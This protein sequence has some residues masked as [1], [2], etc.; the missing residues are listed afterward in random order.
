MTG[1]VSHLVTEPW[2]NVEM[3]MS[4]SERQRNYR[5]RKGARVG[6]KPGPLPTEPCGTSAGAR[7]HERAHEPL[8]DECRVAEATRQ[9]ELYRARRAREAGQ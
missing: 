6:G 5:E 1:T 3:A 2:L 9:R 4:G 8:C 7:R